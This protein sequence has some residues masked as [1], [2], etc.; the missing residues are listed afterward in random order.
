[1]ADMKIV[2]LSHC[3]HSFLYDDIHHKLMYKYDYTM[4][5]PCHMVLCIPHQ[6][7]LD[8]IQDPSTNGHKEG[9][10][11]WVLSQYKYHRVVDNT[12]YHRYD[13]FDN[14]ISASYT[15]TDTFC[16]ATFLHQYF[17]FHLESSDMVGC[18]DVHMVE[19]SR[20]LMCI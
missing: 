12:V 11:F 16:Y 7:D 1:M 17:L 9:A 13:F 14:L 18:K 4:V 20:I 15:E 2:P 10:Q 3:C 6:Q 8:G 19:Y 5:R